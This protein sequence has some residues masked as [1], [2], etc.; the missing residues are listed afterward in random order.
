MLKNNGI[1]SNYLSLYT[2]GS[3]DDVQQ[4]CSKHIQAYYWNNLIENSANY[5]FKWYT[6]ITMHGQQNIKLDAG[7]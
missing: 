6:Y 5:T 7:T 1:V 2:V 3:P 4:A